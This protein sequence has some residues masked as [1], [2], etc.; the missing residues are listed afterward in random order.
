MI[1]VA[2]LAAL[3]LA[4]AAPIHY[5][6]VADEISAKHDEDVHV[7]GAR[8]RALQ[9]E[10]ELAE[11]EIAR[12]AVVAT[13]G[14]AVLPAAARELATLALALLEQQRGA[15]AAEVFTLALAVLEGAFG[16]AQP[17]LE[18][19]K[20]EGRRAVAEAAAAAEEHPRHPFLAAIAG[21]PQGSILI[22]PRT[23]RQTTADL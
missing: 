16:S 17:E 19:F 11:A 12:H 13:Q 6:T 1:C 20:A 2:L 14:R 4:V 9:S 8:L 23:P 15:D 21:A 10:V 7:L 5:S 22:T 3:G 18:A